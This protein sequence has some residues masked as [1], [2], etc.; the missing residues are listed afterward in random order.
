MDSWLVASLLRLTARSAH[1]KLYC[2][3]VS[4]RLHE[5]LVDK[6]FQIDLFEL[7]CRIYQAVAHRFQGF[8]AR[9]RR[10]GDG[11]VVFFVAV[12]DDAVIG[13]PT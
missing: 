3:F 5:P 7:W 11:R 4:A 9:I 6:L 10:P 13:A 2:A 12:V 1:D 8:Q